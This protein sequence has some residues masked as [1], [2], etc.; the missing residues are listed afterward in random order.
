MP[1][2]RTGEDRVGEY[3]DALVLDRETAGIDLDPELAEA[4]RLFQTLGTAPAATAR[5]RVWRTVQ[6][7]ITYPKES[8]HPMLPARI[9][10]SSHPFA[11]PTSPGALPPWRGRTRWALTQLATAALLVLTFVAGIVAF[12]PWRPG[13]APP[14]SDHQLAAVTA[15]TPPAAGEL[16]FLWESTGGPDPMVHPYGVGIDPQGNVWVSDGM[17]DRFQIFAP[18][19]AF[20]EIW[21]VSGTQDGQFDFHATHGNPSADYGDVAFDAGGNIYVADTGNFR[22]QKFAPDRSFLLAWGGE[23]KMDG[24]LMAPGGISVS[25]DGA[26]Y[27]SDESRSDVQMF[28]SDGTL[29]GIIG[30]PGAR[31]GQL[32]TPA[33]VAV[34]DTG[35]AWVADFGNNRIQRFDASGDFLAT[36]GKLG[37]EDGDL[38]SPNDVAVDRLGRIY[39]AD[40]GNNRLQVFAPDG[41]FLAEIGGFGSQPGQ[42]FNPLGVAVDE[43]GIIYIS[44]S[45]RVQ[46]FR[47]VLPQGDA[48]SS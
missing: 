46:A 15:A 10:A 17:N 23:G 38:H 12:G 7:A 2:H 26:V 22:I 11:H 16:E 40:L 29:L 28:A 13:S 14:S 8:E 31:D 24:Q 33:G 27:V 20:L 41:R 44:D 21:G 34:D 6:S 35:D 37:S 45:R 5:E 9:L 4:I 47:L 36:W 32:M 39:V 30:E 42:F 3:W 48:L 19:G 43:A 18:D 25:A 1:D